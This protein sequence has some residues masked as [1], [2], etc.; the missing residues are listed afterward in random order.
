MTLDTAKA[1]LEVR[2]GDQQPP[3]RSHSSEELAAFER[4]LARLRNAQYVLRTLRG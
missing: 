3:A 2:K 1:I 4:R